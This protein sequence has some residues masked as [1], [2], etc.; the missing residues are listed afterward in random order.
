M[1][2]HVG[3]YQRKYNSKKTTKYLNIW[4]AT[5][6][7][8]LDPVFF[9]SLFSQGVRAG[10]Y[11]FCTGSCRTVYAKLGIGIEADAAGIGIPASCISV[12]YWSNRVPRTG[13]R[14]YPGTGVVP[15]KHRHIVHSGTGLTGCR[16]VRHSGIDKNVHLAS[17]H[18]KRW[19][20]IHGWLWWC[21]SCCMMLKTHENAGIPER[22]RKVSPTSACL[23]EVT[24]FSP[25]SAF[26]HKNQSGTA[27]HGLVRHCPAMCIWQVPALLE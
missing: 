21:Y 14:P 4:K 2:D 12:L 22:R 20:G 9:H 6:S 3:N 15:P 25:A 5:W 27:G 19:N 11:R 7:I 26:R 24:F 1:L 17:L 23:P 16:T 18:C 13:S 10:V 8:V